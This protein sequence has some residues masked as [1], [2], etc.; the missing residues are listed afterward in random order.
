MIEPFGTFF[1]PGPT[2]VRPEVLRA[3]A[4]PMIPHRSAAYQAMH[5]RIVNALQ[6]VFRTRRP[7]YLVTASSTALMEAAIRGAPEGPILS[8]VNGAFAERFARVA[9]RCD[10]RTR[11]MT[12]PWGE[13]P[14]M[15]LVEQLL[16]DDHYSA[17]TV[18][19][20]ETSTGALA[21]LRALTELAHRYGTMCLVDSVSGVGGSPVETDAWGLDFVLTG[22]QKALALPPGMAFG[23]ASEAYVL[24]A[25]ATPG[26]G[27]YLD[28][29]EFEEFALKSQTPHT[30][31]LPLLFAADL[32]LATI[33]EQGVASRWARHAAMLAATERWVD[34][35][36][37]DGL[38]IAM[39]PRAGER[40]PT[41]STITLPVGMH[42][43]PVVDKLAENGFVIGTGYGILRDTTIRIGHMGDHS[44]DTLEPCLDAVGAVLRASPR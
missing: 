9:Q 35:C 19:H 4:Q 34:S 6:H 39:L 5:R 20:S 33:V 2:E 31:A 3:M 8:L 1:F 21:D 11:V 29:V 10:R 17:M 18:V 41:V 15:H 23:V 16:S 28:I 40:S 14:S 30:P 25:S 44:V 24:Q 26:R 7:V 43:G 37:G 32:Q 12:V 42:S 27:K 38:A 13:T 36:R 22:S